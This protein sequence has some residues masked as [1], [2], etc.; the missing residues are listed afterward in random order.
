MNDEN[1]SRKYGPTWLLLAVL[2]FFGIRSSTTDSPV[3]STEH[4]KGEAKHRAREETD[5]RESTASGIAELLKSL[6]QFSDVEESDDVKRKIEKATSSELIKDT[7]TRCLIACVPDPVE[8]SSGDR[9][10]TV[11]DAILRAAESQHCVLD[12]YY[13]P[14]PREEGAHKGLPARP[15][16]VPPEWAI[17][18][19]FRDRLTRETED[20]P[21]SRTPGLLLFRDPEGTVLLIFLVG[22]TETAGIHK[23]AFL[24]SLDLLSRSTEYKSTEYK[25]PR[26]VKVLGP[27]FSGSQESLQRVIGPWSNQKADGPK[28]Y[29]RIISG[30]ATALEKNKLDRELTKQV[31]FQATVIPELH[32]IGALL[33]YL[34]LGELEG[35]RLAI[36]FESNTTFGQKAIQLWDKQPPPANGPTLFPFP[37]HISEVRT[38]YDKTSGATKNNTLNLPSFGSKLRLNLKGS[39]DL[40]DTEPTL[41]PTMTAVTTE[42]TLAQMLDT[43]SHERFRYV[44]IVATDIKDRLFLTTLV[45]EHCPDCRLVFSDSD[46]LLAH[47]DYSA[48]LRGSIVGSTYPLRSKTQ[49]W[50]FP[51]LGKHDRLIFPGSREQGYYNATVALLN[52][53]DSRKLLDYGPPFPSLYSDQTCSDKDKVQKDLPP[54]WI[55]IIGQGGLYPLAVIPAKGK[56]A[57]GDYV[58][59]A[60][61]PQTEEN[62]SK[63]PQKEQ[64]KAELMVI[65]GSLW[66]AP[67]LGMILLLIYVGLAYSFAAVVSS[68]KGNEASSGENNSRGDEASS[69]D[70]NSWEMRTLFSPRG[71][72]MRFRQCLYVFIC[73]AS[74]SAVYAYLTYVW[75]IPF[76]SYALETN[77]P[78]VIPD[79]GWIAPAILLLL[80]L[81][82]LILLLVRVVG[83]TWS[84]DTSS[85]HWMFFVGPVVYIGLLILS[86]LNCFSGWILIL[87]FILVVYASP[88]LLYLRW[89]RS[90]NE[91]TKSIF[92]V[93][94]DIKKAWIVPLL[95]SLFLVGIMAWYYFLYS[96]DDPSLTE[97]ESKVQRL[98]FSERAIGLANGITPVVP[99]L[100]L[101]IALF[102]WA[103]FQLRRQYLLKSPDTP[104]LFPSDDKLGKF[105]QINID[106]TDL[107]KYLRNPFEAVNT[108]AAFLVWVLLFYIFYRLSSLYVPAFEGW[109]LA[110]FL[111]LGLAVLALLIVY[112][113][114]LFLRVWGSTRSLLRAIALLPLAEAFAHIPSA[115]TAIF[116]PNLTSEGSGQNGLLLY[117]RDQY[118]LLAAEYGKLKKVEENHDLPEN[119]KT[120]VEEAMTKPDTNVEQKLRVAATACLRLLNAIWSEATLIE[121]FL[122]KHPK[123]ADQKWL[124][125]AQDYVALEIAVYLNKLFVQLRNMALFLSLAPLLFLL[126]VSSYPFQPQRVWVWL[127][128]GLIGLVTL[129][130]LGIVIQ[131]ER[132][133][134]VSRI[135]KTTPGQ[136]DWRWSFFSH[137][138]FYAIPLLSI[139]VTMSDSVSD[140]LHSWLDPLLQAIK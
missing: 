100:M 77:S 101:G 36:L 111:L 113:W 10:D 117:R 27:G 128:I 4:P 14:W 20:R 118:R 120:A 132:D 45:R 138:G 108:K 29:F 50:S 69:S 82:F 83:D 89:E 8:S 106:A 32:V 86:L 57:Y 19:T 66:V 60:K 12:R 92:T 65:H 119:D 124:A 33:K 6:K 137:L 104:E 52:P 90:I 127:A 62:P 31:P 51:F 85:W 79:R 102:G 28:P 47:P 38:A 122:P 49:T 61:T 91:F 84:I 3:P 46:L 98:L 94:E 15:V 39:E 5:G 95:I 59:R 70:E 131:A 35:G 7:K 99:I 105:K 81:A 41:H 75:L 53:A 72:K 30:S 44:L 23:Q 54:V 116:G 78:V 97:G 130:I 87:I 140:L 25:P 121:Q 93:L 133:E 64:P 125:L 129:S 48:D 18:L 58:F 24:A 88:F 76:Y 56:D 2:A 135:A 112:S 21:W 134:V 34:N 80:L 74:V 11:I 136:L 73:L 107:D 22:E 26:E 114:L 123:D 43:M 126:A 103:Y 9:F 139:L 37:L 16:E 13:Y 42:R 109:I 40:R 71:S 1:S 110:G 67:V 17:G 115:I 63:E 96:K 55:S 68:P